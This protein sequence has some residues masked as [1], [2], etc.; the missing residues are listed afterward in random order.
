MSP[1]RVF[2]LLIPASSTPNPS[3][4]TSYNERM[5]ITIKPYKALLAH[6]RV[7]AQ[8]SHD[9]NKRTRDQSRVR[10]RRNRAHAHGVGPVMNAF[11]ISGIGLGIVDNKKS[12]W[13]IM[14]RPNHQLSRKQPS[15]L[16][17]KIKNTKGSEDNHM[18][19]L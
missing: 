1:T 5:E 12:K 15:P 11:G 10:T 18:P 9:Q 13:D 7:T 17:Q 14:S 2:P 16:F 4:P 8:M 19:Q 3:V 6:I